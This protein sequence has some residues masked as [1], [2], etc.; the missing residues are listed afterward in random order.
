MKLAARAGPPTMTLDKKAFFARTMHSPDSP[1]RAALRAA[2]REVSRAL[3]PLHRQLIEYAKAEYAFAVGPVA[4]PADLIH[5]LTD[6]P[7]FAWLK[8]VTALIVDIDEMARTDFEPEAALAIGD[9][10]QELF[11]RGDPASLF[12][13]HYVAALQGDAEVAIAHAD[14]R[15]AFAPLRR[16][17]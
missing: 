6:D 10:V 5:L 17:P 2:L 9:R 7:F 13:Q 8:P 12:T 15:K 14:L 4:R 16:R 11:T 1:E 3:L